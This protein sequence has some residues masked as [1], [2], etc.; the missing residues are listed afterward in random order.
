MGFVTGAREVKNEK[1]IQTVR[2]YVVEGL[3]G[4]ICSRW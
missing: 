2:K 1:G 3:L 4:R